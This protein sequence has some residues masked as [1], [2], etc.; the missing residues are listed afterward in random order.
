MREVFK[1]ISPV[2]NASKIRKPLMILHGAKD[3]RV[4]LGQAEE[5]ARAVAGNGA[6]V[7]KVV[8]EDEGHFM[9]AKR[10]NNDFTFYAWIL[11]MERFLLNGVSGS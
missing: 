10:E 2:T 3:T 5:M 11:F 6:P 4:P 1:R 8:F 9:F 7:W